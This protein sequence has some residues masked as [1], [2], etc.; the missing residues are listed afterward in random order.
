MLRW[1][2]LF[3]IVAII[4]AVFGFGGI[5]PDASWIAKDSLLRLADP[6]RRVAHSEKGTAAC[7]VT[8]CLMR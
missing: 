3:L 5:A 1:A 6:V 4:A 7:C 8:S 2:L